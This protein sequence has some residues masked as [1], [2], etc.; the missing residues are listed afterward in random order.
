MAVDLFGPG[1]S[2]E[3]SAATLTGRFLVPQPPAGHRLWVDTSHDDWL[4]LGHAPAGSVD[5][6]PVFSMVRVPLTAGQIV[7]QVQELEAEA[8]VDRVTSG[9]WS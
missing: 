1:G 6:D 3:T 2:V 7:G 4:Y 9:G 8:W 5:T